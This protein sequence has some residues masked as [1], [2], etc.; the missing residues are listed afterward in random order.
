MVVDHTFS[1]DRRLPRAHRG[2]GL[3]WHDMVKKAI[4]F[5]V[6]QQDHGLA[7]DLWIAGQGIQH[8]GNV[9]GAIGGRIGGVFRVARRGDNPGNLRKTI[10]QNIFTQRRYAAR[11]PSPLRQR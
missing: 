8:P 11:S 2:R 9:N 3:R 5:V 1:T 7:P 10:L 6:I 4:V